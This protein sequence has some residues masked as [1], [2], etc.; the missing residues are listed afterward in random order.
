MRPPNQR[1]ASKVRKFLFG[2][3][4]PFAPFR[5]ENGRNVHHLAFPRY[6]PFDPYFRITLHRRAYKPREL[7]HGALRA[8]YNRQDGGLNPRQIP[9]R[10]N[11]CVRYV[12]RSPAYGKQVPGAAAP[13]TGG[14]GGGAN[15]ETRRLMDEDVRYFA[16]QLDHFFF[17]G[18]LERYITIETGFDVVGP[19][20]AGLEGR[21]EGETVTIREADGN[22]YVRIRINTGQRDLAYELDDI[23]GQLMHEMIHAYF[24]IYS[25]DCRRCE[26]SLLNTTGLPND[27]HG[28]IFLMLHRLILSEIRR[29]GNA[30][31]NGLAALL[32]D[33]CPDLSVSLNSTWRA[34]AAIRALTQAQRKTYTKV[35][36]YGFSTNHLVRITDT[37]RV[38]VRPN[39]KENQIKV[40]NTLYDKRSRADEYRVDLLDNWLAYEDEEFNEDNGENEEEDP[41]DGLI[42]VDRDAIDD[43]EDSNV[44]L[45]P[46]EADKV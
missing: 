10:V 28:P 4:V 37:D 19:D 43:E 7:L 5:D 39:L 3:I 23:L 8:F 33:D 41:D 45:V 15:D 34:N 14:G 40:E 11:F 13:G 35:R 9:A 2:V 20:P 21:I 29:W 30:G 25:C 1:R 6:A 12:M 32:E 24:L 26:P 17:F 36:A 44:D 27:G 31:Q 42:R 18:L 38:A 16:Q 46:N 22:E